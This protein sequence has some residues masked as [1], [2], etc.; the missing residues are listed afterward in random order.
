MQ[1]RPTTRIA[2]IVVSAALAVG[3]A[4][5]TASAQ[6]IDDS[7]GAG[8]ETTQQYADGETKLTDADRKVVN[9]SFEKMGLK[10]LP[11]EVDTLK[12]ENDK[13]VAL[14][15][16]GGEVTLDKSVDKPKPGAITAQAGVGDEI[17]RVVGACLGIDF[18]AATSAW[19]AIESQVTDWDKAAKFVLR[20]VGLIAALSCGGG[21]FAEYLL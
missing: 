9:D 13:I 12:T 20:R 3:L 10:P 6:S 7:K 1:L 14:D 21:V 4:S 17:K 8:I 19:A 11:D 16:G 2:T 5:G 15:A 18:F